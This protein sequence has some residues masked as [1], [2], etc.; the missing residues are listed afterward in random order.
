MTNAASVILMQNPGYHFLFGDN[1]KTVTVVDTFAFFFRAYF[2]L[3][4]LKSPS[5]FP[6]GL[7]TGF[8]N[9]VHQLQRE[10]MTDYIVFALDSKKG[11]FRK[12]FYAEYKANR[13]SPPE[14]LI[15]QLGVAIEWIEKMGFKT[16]TKD[17]YEAD[18]VIATVMKFAK[19]QGIVGKMVSSDKDL[20]QLIYDDQIFL[21][22]WVK[23]KNIGVD[24]CVAKFGVKPEDFVDFQALL[25]DTSDNVPGV[26]GIGVKTASKMINEYHTLEALYKNI[27]KAG[28]K[29]IQN[30]LLEHK[31]EAFISRDLVKLRDDIFT[32]CPLEEYT[33]ED[34]NYLSALKDEFEEYGMKQAFRYASSEK[35]SAKPVKEAEKKEQHS[36]EAIT[37][38]SKEKLEEVFKLIDKEAVVAFDTETTSLDTKSTK[39]VGFSF[40]VDEQKA[41]YVPVAHSYLGVPEQLPLKDAK[42]AVSKILEYKVVGQNLKFDFEVLWHYLDIEPKELFADTMIM[43]WLLDPGSRVGLDALAKK[44]FNYEMISFKS[45]VKKGE[46]FSS[47]TIEEATKYA[48][49]DAWMTLK[50]YCKL[51][52]MYKLGGLEE[53]FNEAKSVEYPFL[54]TL[55]HIESYGI[56]IDTEYLKEFSEHLSEELQQLSQRIYELAGGEFNIRST[57]QLGQILF[58]K[59]ALKGGKKTK[60]GYSTNESVL[61]SLRGEHEIIDEILEYRQYQKILST[62]AKPLLKLAMENNENR[63]YTTFVQTGTATGRLASKDPNLQ[64]IPV[65]SE[66]GRRVRRAFV[67]KEGYS[68]VSI[69]YSQ[70]ELRL[71]AH[72]SGDKSL[73]EAFLEDKD[74]HLETAI[75]LFGEEA[76]QKRSFAKSINFGLLYGMG[77]RKLSQ[78]LGITASEAKEII[79]NYFAAF[80]T[81][82]S[83]LESIQERVKQQGYVETL[84]KRRRVFDYEGANAMAKAA[85]LRESVN[86]VFQG[87]A[88]DLIKMAMLDIKRAIEEEGL[89]AKI[90]LQIHDELIFEVRESEAIEQAERFA[91]MMEN[92]YPLEVKLKSSVSIAKSWDK[93]K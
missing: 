71:L 64:N 42:W 32:S 2:A 18:D 11:N 82:K 16:L 22:D 49:E 31:E 21:Y 87:S 52:D 14:D 69:D 50:L 28:T 4:P 58:G 5:G 34:K 72:F 36:F 30:L 79:T 85:I 60:T 9:F 45:S 75:K 20:Y 89:D 63:I 23:R 10:H 37:L 54:L 43:A 83:Y 19:E 8:V 62:Y 73:R 13:P 1:L 80:P 84:L 29:R 92:I 56:K 48:A 70:I 76:E 39:L 38:D 74:I 90:L 35:E 33:F 61:Q 26:K 91:Y 57:Q 41:Y 78:E 24:E 12:E 67:A 53:L 93:L 25:G 88:A 40:A 6:T 46:N 27:E 44:F 15:A 65:R 77:S 55:M 51:I 66:L 17:G 68:L 47:V 7:L 81:V 3:P 86:T 59:L